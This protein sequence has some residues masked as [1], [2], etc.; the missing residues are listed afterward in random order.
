[1]LTSTDPHEEKTAVV[2][3]IAHEAA[4]IT[5][6]EDPKYHALMKAQALRSIK[7]KKF[8]LLTGVQSGNLLAPGTMGAATGNFDTFI[9]SALH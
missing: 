9:V 8:E 4:I 2:G 7:P 3:T 6:L 1:M 5:P